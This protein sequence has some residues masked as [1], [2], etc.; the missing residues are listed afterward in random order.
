MTPSASRMDKIFHALGDPTRRA[1]IE[2][3]SNGPVPASSLIKPLKISLAAVVQHLQVL[4]DSGLAKTKKLGRTRVC[5]V[6]P[7]GFAMVEQWIAN[8]RALWEKRYD[9][10]GQLLNADE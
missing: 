5:E 7:Q 2:R 8:R 1:L 9:K 4:E 6:E 10:L 3:L